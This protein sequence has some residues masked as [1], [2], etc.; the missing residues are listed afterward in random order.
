MHFALYISL[1]PQSLVESISR[2][3]VLSSESLD[4]CLGALASIL[5][6]LV[7]LADI[8]ELV[9]N[10]VGDNVWVECI[11]LSLGHKRVGGQE[12]A[13]GCLTAGA[14]KLEVH[15]RRALAKVSTGET[16]G[17]VR[18][19]G[20]AAV[21]CGTGISIGVG[22]G[23]AGRVGAGGGVGASSRRCGV[24]CRASSTGIRRQLIPARIN[25]GKV[26]EAL[27][28]H[29]LRHGKTVRLKWSGDRGGRVGILG[30]GT[31]DSRID[32]RNNTTQLLSGRE[33]GIS[34]DR[35]NVHVEGVEVLLSG[36]DRGSTTDDR[37]ISAQSGDY[38]VCQCE[39]TLLSVHMIKQIY[40][41]VIGF[42]QRTLSHGL[43]AASNTPGTA[44]ARVAA[45]PGLPK[46]LRAVTLDTG[47]CSWPKRAS[48]KAVR[49]MKV[50]NLDIVAVVG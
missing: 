47:T 15:G 19:C 7:G 30:I 20:G 9:A 18:G 12:R 43:A 39:L 3:L 5:C 23:A 31:C 32:Q 50:K 40:M 14:A 38:F 2:G 17:G 22:I 36:H 4:Q 49:K 45:S 25:R 34:T 48:A 29:H 28:A 11:L 46:L 1:E 8:G 10:A 44:P 37:R 35:G 41:I 6:S 13:L 21:G 26:R 33:G 24:A 27:L 42:D 16:G